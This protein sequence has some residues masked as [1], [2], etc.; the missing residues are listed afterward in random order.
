V[1]QDARSLT[2]LTSLIWDGRSASSSCASA[3]AQGK[4]W[5]ESHNEGWFISPV[6]SGGLTLPPAASAGLGLWNA[7]AEQN[8]HSG[9]SIWRCLAASSRNRFANKSG[10][11][12]PIAAKQIRATLS[13]DLKSSPKH[14][15]GSLRIPG[16]GRWGNLMILALMSPTHWRQRS[17]RALIGRLWRRWPDDGRRSS[18]GRPW[19]HRS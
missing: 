13:S 4:P 14:R 2:S 6:E 1:A 18:K 19:L 8:T 16:S 11:S 5:S 15:A 9:R 10:L 3:A 12:T 7:T 17:G